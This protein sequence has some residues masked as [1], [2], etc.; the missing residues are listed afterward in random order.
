LHENVQAVALLIYRTPQVVRFALDREKHLVH[1][2]LIARP[3]TT[4][5][6][7]IGV[8]LP[9]LATPFADRLIGDDYATFE[10]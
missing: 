10:Q 4:A 2:P 6:Q 9:K 8:L 7:F 1:V 5:T 3:R